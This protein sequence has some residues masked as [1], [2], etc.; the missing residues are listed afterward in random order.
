M[1]LAILLLV[2]STAYLGI[3]PCYYIFKIAA[4]HDLR[5]KWLA[6]IPGL[7]PLAICSIRGLSW[8]RILIV[9]LPVPFYFIPDPFM[10]QIAIGVTSVISFL[11]CLTFLISLACAVHE[12]N[13]YRLLLML[14]PGV[15][16][17]YLRYLAMRTDGRP[18]VKK[19][20]SKTMDCI[21]DFL[22]NV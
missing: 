18:L 21:D 16:L 12:E 6:L 15:Q 17:F 11:M 5:A 22:F 9:Y 3:L 7:W 14:I 19:Q 13:R 2:L 20:K 8:W 10:S 1:K 4:K